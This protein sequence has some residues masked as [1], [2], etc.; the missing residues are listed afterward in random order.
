MEIYIVTHYYRDSYE[1]A[2]YRN[3]VDA[4]YWSMNKLTEYQEKYRSQYPYYNFQT[5]EIGPIETFHYSL[6]ELIEQM[7]RERSIRV[8]EI[9]DDAMSYREI[10]CTITR[11]ILQ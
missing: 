2:T 5:N 3:M 9:D 6:E 11:S 7:W 4:Y 10:W 8:W 1:Y